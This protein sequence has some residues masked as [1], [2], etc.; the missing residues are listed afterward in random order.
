MAAADADPATKGALSAVRV[1]DLTDER[2]IYGAKLLADLGADT[3]RVEPPEGDPLRT[4]GPFAGEGGEAAS[5][6]YGFFASSRRSV[7][8]DGSTPAGR[9]QIER[10]ALASDI[11]MDCGKLE[12][13]GIEFQQ[14]LDKN[15]S[16][17]LVR[18]S[19]FGPDGPWKDYLAPD[20][21]ASALGGICATTG[22][23]ET[24][25]LKGFG[26]LAFYASG[27]YAAIAALAALNHV[28]DGGKGQ[29]VDVPV[30]LCIAS[31][32]EH[33]FMWY[34]YHDRIAMARGP[35][36]PRRG[37]LHWSNAYKVMQARGGS[38]MITPTPDME[39]QVMWLVE[40]DAHGDLL[41]ERWTD[42]EMLAE[43]IDYLMGLLADWVGTKDVEPFFHE[44][45][46]R[47][48][49]FGWVL[50]IERVAENPQLEARHWWRNYAIGGSQIRGPGPPYHFSD[51]PW[52]ASAA[53]E[54][55][56]ATATVLAEIGWEE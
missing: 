1:L 45:Q 7:T 20:L 23:V 5:L 44:A 55:G 48:H 24:P 17:V 15:P 34:W 46:A 9:R 33:V 31:C 18:V 22:D 37:S 38:I 25:P 29:I 6:W 8:F 21:V 39:R 50:P 14:L 47:H 40:E 36:L 13:A 28:R 35:V 27:A 11:V 16:L 3:V 19:S 52:S 42:P 51:T 32:L 43:F 49:P 26:E 2:A 12:A 10:L 41:D 53:G 54:A 4:R 56:A 30:H